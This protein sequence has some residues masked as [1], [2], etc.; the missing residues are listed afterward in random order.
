[1]RVF[2]PRWRR[3][4]AAVIDP[5]CVKTQKLKSDEN[6]FSSIEKN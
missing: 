4:G 2:L 6:D 1:M 5:G 3:S